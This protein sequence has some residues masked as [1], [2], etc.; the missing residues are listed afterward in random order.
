MAILEIYSNRAPAKIL[1][2]EKSKVL[3][4]AGGGEQIVKSA[5]TWHFG[6]G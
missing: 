1:S 6:R 4:L 3:N 5:L 2:K